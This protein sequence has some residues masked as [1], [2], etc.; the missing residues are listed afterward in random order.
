MPAGC[1]VGARAGA[2]FVSRP[3]ALDA[4]WVPGR[5]AQ[6]RLLCQY[7]QVACPAVRRAEASPRPPIAS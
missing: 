3:P 6:R 5:C 4:R 1:P 2:S 7:A